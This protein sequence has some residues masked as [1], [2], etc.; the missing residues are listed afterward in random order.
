MGLFLPISLLI[1]TTLFTGYNIANLVYYNRLRKDSTAAAGISKENAN[2]MFWLTVI[3][4]LISLGFWIYSIVALV[5]EIR[6]R[7]KT[8]GYQPLPTKSTVVPPS[9][10]PQNVL[11]NPSVPLRPEPVV[12]KP[13]TNVQLTRRAGTCPAGCLTKAQCNKSKAIPPVA[14]T[15]TATTGTSPIV[16]PRRRIAPTTT[17]AVAPIRMIPPTTA[18][19]PPIRMIPPTVRV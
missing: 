13:I 4:L 16:V 14:P 11:E 3:L 7:G 9:R 18:P 1:V 17:T 12:P 19:V 10:I 2:A 15:V 8:A 6:Q 5:K